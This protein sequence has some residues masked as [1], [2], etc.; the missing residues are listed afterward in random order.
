MG[1]PPVVHMGIGEG[2]VPWL[3]LLDCDFGGFF[4]PVGDLTDQIE[5]AVNPFLEDL[6]ESAEMYIEDD[7]GLGEWL[8]KKHTIKKELVARVVLLLGEQKAD[9]Q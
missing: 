8:E 4:I 9:E 6:T 5:Q 3:S 1:E 7:L 2:D